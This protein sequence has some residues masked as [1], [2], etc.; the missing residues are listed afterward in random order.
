M[1][2]YGSDDGGRYGEPLDDFLDEPE[3]DDA[4]AMADGA[5]VADDAMLVEVG[6]DGTS[7][8]VTQ[9]NG[10]KGPKKHAGPGGLMALQAPGA[11]TEAERQKQAEESKKKRITSPYM[12]K[13]EKA[14][15][16][17][18]RALQISM[19]APVMTE[20]NGETDSLVIAMKE[21]REKKIP[22]VV[23]RHLPDGSYEDWGVD[24]LI[25]D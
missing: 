4:D 10:H 1:S 17:G 2:D 7:V 16:L 3:Y 15:I 12:T 19:N 6:A 21:L 5:E 22:L 11:L 20:L 23:R 14:R 18:T 25:V 9:A 8:N 13:Y 24:E